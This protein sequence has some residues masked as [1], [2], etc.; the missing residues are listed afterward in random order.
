MFLG[1]LL[2]TGM[3]IHDASAAPETAPAGQ[4]SIVAPAG[5]TPGDCNSNGIPDAT[6]IASGTSEDCNGNGVPDECDTDCNANGIP[7]SCDLSDGTSEDCNSNGIPD[8]C[9][10]GDAVTQT[11]QEFTNFYYGGQ[12]PV[13]DLRGAR[14]AKSAVRLDFT[15]RGS[16]GTDDTK[17]IDVYLGYTTPTLV[18]KVNIRPGTTPCGSG[19]QV[20]LLDKSVFNA[21]EAY[22][23]FQPGP[24][25]APGCE[26]SYLQVGISYLAPN[27]Q[28]DCNGNSVPD[29]CE[30]DCNSNGTPD[31]CDIRS[32]TSKDCNANGVPDECDI[33]KGTSKDCNSNAIPDECDIRSGRSKD[34]NSNSIPDECDIRTGISKDC[35]SNGVPDDCDIRTGTSKDCNSNGIPD[36]CDIKNGTA[37]DCNANGVPDDCDMRSGTS[38]DCNSN[39]IPDE[40]D[41]STGKSKDSNGNGVPDECDIAGGT[42]GD[43]NGNGVPDDADITTNT[44]A[45]KVFFEDFESGKLDNWSAGGLWHIVDTTSSDCLDSM[46]PEQD[47]PGKDVAGYNRGKDH[48]DYNTGSRTSGYLEMTTSVTLPAIGADLVWW[49]WIETEDTPKVDVWQVQVSADN[50]STWTTIF[51][52]NGKSEP[53]WKQY[54]VSLYDYRGKKVKIRFF[55]DSMDKYNNAFRG[56]YVDDVTIY[57][58]DIFSMDVNRNGIPDECEP[59]CNSNGVP[60]DIDIALKTS[61]DCDANGVPDEC[62]SCDRVM[63]VT[64]KYSPFDVEQP[65]AT[66]DIPGAPPAHG[67]VRMDFWGNGNFGLEPSHRIDI[68][69]G[70]PTPSLVGNVRIRLADS[71]CAPAMKPFILPGATFNKYQPHFVFQPG[72]DISARCESSYL[73][74]AI[75]YLTTNYVKD[76]NANDSPDE[77]DIASGVSKDCNGNGVPDECDITTGTSKDCNAN[78][79][80]DE[81][82]I[83]DGTSKDCNA[84]GVPDECDLAKKT[85]PDC[86]GN[87][88]PDECDLATGTSPD[89]NADL[90]PDECDIAYLISQDTQPDGIPDECQIEYDVPLCNNDYAPTTIWFDDFENPEANLWTTSTLSGACTWYYPPPELWLN[91]YSGYLH[92][93]G[94]RM[95]TPSDSCL[96]QRD[97]MEIPTT[98]P[99]FLIFHHQY[100]FEYYPANYDGGIVEY[101][102]DDA[103]T[104]WTD[105][106]PYIDVN[107]YRG[108]IAHNYYSALADRKAFVGSSLGYIASRADMTTFAGKRVKIRFRAATDWAMVSNGWFV[109]DVQLVT[110][111]FKTTERQQDDFPQPPLGWSELSRIPSAGGYSATDYD[112]TQGA[113]VARVASDENRYRVAG[114][115]T[116]MSNWLPYA[117]VGTDRYVRAKFYVYAT[118][119]QNPGQL[120]TIPNF[121]MRVAT[122]FAVN[123]MLEV[124]SHVN[125]AA[126]DEPVTLDVRPSTDPS[127]PSLYRVDFA[128]VDV[129]QLVNHPWT[130]GIL[131]GFE[132]YCLDPQ[133]N[134]DVCLAES[135]IGT[136]PRNWLTPEASSLMWVKTYQTSPPTAGDFD[137]AN[138]DT[139]TDVVSLVVTGDGTLPERDYTNVPTVTASA[140]GLTLDSTVFDNYA[141]GYSIGTAQIDLA[142]GDNSGR[143]RVEPGKQYVARFHVTSTQHSN[144]NP[145]LRLRMRT[146]RFGWVQKFEIGGAWAINTPEHVALAS[147]AL[148]GIGCMNPDKLGGEN[149]GWYTV[150]LHTP[151]NPDIR[152]DIEGTLWD[153]MPN[154][155]AEPG[156]GSV[157]PSLRDLKVGVDLIDTMSTSA[158]KDL[159]AGNFTVDRIE[160]FSFNTIPD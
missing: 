42:S 74:V 128:P 23:K 2:A 70:T 14:T 110:C 50:G 73:Q 18:G 123:S 55:F 159:E 155:C 129:P 148:P 136:Y 157:S 11:S 99:C 54:S 40:C 77:C 118:G 56:W 130:E 33:D 158:N 17:R 80:P 9:D 115:Y 5:G 37:K 24:G 93:W 41:I 113:L 1:G 114:W 65:P 116:D 132:A 104:T 60:D 91:P 97:F 51:N 64:P 87:N 83:A 140:S 138:P 39:H 149:G 12:T 32:G 82:D 71:P 152:P 121:R 111:T 43:C 105:L 61:V 6:D 101:L 98:A 48:C 4:D 29:V 46:P 3:A 69:M 45:T 117:S 81:C 131:R 95:G 85:S 49:N 27:S 22:F 59:D 36:E 53:E 139:T 35:N 28:K 21:S 90:I 112:A 127:R 125:S 44:R 134:G 67:T 146:L 122:R 153:K 58:Y 15:G 143:V 96:E 126:G 19:M 106:G 7:D 57:G 133:D 76:C 75:S 78:G 68:Y 135:S 160:M 119:Q 141:H 38:K 16:F 86:N 30:T 92:A 26:S 10:T 109:D 144:L 63:V 88:V 89:C 79:V 100:D 8:E 150:L 151:M 137:L 154:L 31:D 34:C 102:T 103:G 147:Q 108:T 20:F 84:N 107:G 156:P 25:I 52:G 94:G 66:F 124:N 72:E 47:P 142:A 13:F 120:N 145:Q 62:D